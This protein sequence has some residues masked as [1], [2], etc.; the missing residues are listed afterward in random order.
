[1]TDFGIT[2]TPNGFP[3]SRLK[4]LEKLELDLDTNKITKASI[5]HILSMG[6][7]RE[8]KIRL[9]NAELANTLLPKRIWLYKTS[10]TP[11]RNWVYQK[12][13]LLY[14]LALVRR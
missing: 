5:E 10:T 8:I 6:N 9:Y 2:G 13:R 7:L 1:M 4:Y 3:M 14:I 11:E 12:P